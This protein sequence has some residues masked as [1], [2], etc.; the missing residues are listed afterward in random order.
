MKRLF[1]G[2]IFCIAISALLLFLEYCIYRLHS[3]G[4]ALYALVFVTYLFLINVGAY[5]LNKITSLNIVCAHFFMLAIVLFSSWV[6]S[7][8]T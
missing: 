2:T 3:V 1:R 6:L 4:N 5:R 8:S 7:I